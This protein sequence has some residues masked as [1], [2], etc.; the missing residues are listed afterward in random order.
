[1]KIL[2]I[3]SSSDIARNL[4]DNSNPQFEFIELTS[5]PTHTDQFQIDV[6]NEESYP[7]IEGEVNGIVY[8]PGSINLRPFSSLKLSD[9][10]KD[11]EINVLGLI[12]TLKHC[13]KQLST[14][15]SVV[16]ISSVAASLGMPYHASISM[17]KAAILP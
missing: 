11:Y 10:Q 6:Q 2:L 15:S 16:L 1:M 4:V 8:F 5:T 7:H 14:D 13:H 17:C 9:F 12:K 3:G